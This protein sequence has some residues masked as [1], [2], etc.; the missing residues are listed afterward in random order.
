MDNKVQ[1]V[2]HLVEA[3]GIEYKGINFKNSSDTVTLET[4]CM[5]SS[6]EFTVFLIVSWLINTFSWLLSA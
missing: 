5:I 1:S 4:L 6:G 2:L 3:G